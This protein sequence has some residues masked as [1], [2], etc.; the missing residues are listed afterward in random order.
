M[1]NSTQAGPTTSSQTWLGEWWLIPKLVRVVMW[2]RSNNLYNI[3]LV[4]ALCFTPALNNLIII[5]GLEV[6]HNP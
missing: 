2:Y 6:Q 4:V 5:A 1:A 3:S